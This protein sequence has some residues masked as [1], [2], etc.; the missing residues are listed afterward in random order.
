M[1]LKTHLKS[2]L[3]RFRGTLNYEGLNVPLESDIVTDAIL[4][5]LWAGI[6]GQP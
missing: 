5:T 4:D 6:Y 3:R 2:R 1:K